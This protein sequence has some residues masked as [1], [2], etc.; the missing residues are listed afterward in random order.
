[1]GRLVPKPNPNDLIGICDAIAKLDAKLNTGSAPTFK[2]VGLTGLT[3]SRLVATDASKIF[4]SVADLTAWIAGTANQIVVTSD[5]DGSV[6]LSTPQDIHTGASPTFVGGTFSAVVIGV[7]PTAG[8]H[9]ATKEY[10]DLSGLSGKD[11]WLS[12]T[13]SG[14]GSNYVMYPMETG[15]GQSTLVS[16]GETAGDDQLIFQWITEA[17]EPGLLEIRTGTYSLHSH[18]NRGSGDPVTTVYFKLFKVDADGTS[19]ETELMESEVSD[20]LGTS[21]AHV[22]LHANPAAD[23][24]MDVTSRLIIKMYSNVTGGGTSN[25]TVT[26]E[27][28]H[29]CHLSIQVP[30]SI[31]QN[32]GDVLDDLNVLGAVGADSEFLVGTG[33]GALAWESGNTVRTSLG[34]AIGTDVLAQQTIGIADDNLLEVDDAD[35]ANTDY[36]RFTANGLQGRDAT[37]VKTDLGLVIGT[38]VQAYDADLDNLS[39]CQ[40]GASAAVALLT[41]TEVE[42]LD[43]ATVTTTELNYLDG[44]TLGTAVASKVLAVDASLDIGTIRNLAITGTFSDGNY[45]FDTNGN[46]SGLGT[47]G[48][49]VITQSGTTLA[50]T[51]QPLDAELT[52]LAALSY[53]SASFVKMTGANTFALRTIAQTADDLE[54]TIDHDNLANTHS[55]DIFKTIAVA[56][57][58]N[59]VADSDTDT[60]T[61]VAGTNV[62]ITTNAGADSVT[63]N[64]T[65]GGGGMDYV[66]RGDPAAWDFT[67]VDFTT[68]NTWR[69]LDLSGIVPVGAVAVHMMI[70]IRDNAANSELLFRKN[71]NTNLHNAGRINTQV[72]NIDIRQDIIVACDAN[73]V[74]EYKGAPA[75]FTFIYVIVR[76][77]WIPDGVGAHTH[78]GDTLQLDAINSDGGAFSFA[79][80][81]AV[82]F[83]QAIASDKISVTTT[84]AIGFHV[85]HTGEDA[86]RFFLEKTGGTAGGCMYQGG[87]TAV[88]YYD[89]LG[90]Y[91]FRTALYADMQNG[92]PGDNDVTRL[93]LA[94]NGDVTMTAALSGA[95]TITATDLVA[96]DDVT[97]GERVAHQGDADTYIEFRAD[98]I[99]LVAGG[100]D[101]FTID[102]SGK[103]PSLGFFSNIATQQPHILDVAAAAGDPPTK[104]EYDA[105]AVK[106]NT[107]LG[108]LESY[109]L[110]KAV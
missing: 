61:L 80:T 91:L 33:A 70:Y 105:F 52:S 67:I 99:E 94:A 15:E 100:N 43:G 32:Q 82:T 56:G 79:T 12:D 25:V 85:D 6:T 87:R 35:A 31:W 39:G 108:D 36:A 28:A 38:N 103:N 104:A 1:M 74:I 93:T 47:V 97:I 16:S 7:L 19:N 53:V 48:C 37:E 5:G 57:Q 89:S 63:I 34:L 29:D 69:T 17:N 22:L 60:L 106:F 13:A 88:L 42:I 21:A 54:G 76:G 55:S 20:A 90:S 26:M 59:V 81:G 78:D 68:D 109:G 102:N 9:F 18:L 95:T 41:Q 110:L 10:V 24:A 44:T 72:A 65:G 86:A 66:D 3:A 83:N 107:L 101:L 30:S 98:L 14:V 50:N 92:V 46:V 40:A 75:G 73:R 45:T 64:S 84:E 49:G 2:S 27:G 71:G 4:A 8:A 96:Y 77:W 58:S 62:T 11:Y 51:Y 23:V